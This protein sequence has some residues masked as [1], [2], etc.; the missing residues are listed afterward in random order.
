MFTGIIQSF[1]TVEKLV[2]GPASLELYVRTPFEAYALGE[3]IAVDGVCLTVA[4]F[5]RETFVAVASEETLTKTTLSSLRVGDRV[6]LERALR[7]GDALGGH[8]VSGHVD[9]VGS[10]ARIQ[11]NGTA[12]ILAFD[13]PSELLPFVAQ[14]G[15]IAVAGVSLTVNATT[16]KGF[17]VTV[18]PHTGIATN[19]AKLQRGDKVNIEVDLFARYVHRALQ[20]AAQ[21]GAQ[22]NSPPHADLSETLKR[23]GY[24]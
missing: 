5:S 3:S 11:P 8:M 1:G 10:L 24:T 21:P 20:F 7:M 14:K 22:G 12:W 15:S 19:L 23:A 16:P 17:E 6:H 2:H 9:G 13:L 18:V 4:S